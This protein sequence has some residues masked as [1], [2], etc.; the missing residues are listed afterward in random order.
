MLLV[1]DLIQS[2]NLLAEQLLLLSV[3]TC[4]STGPEDST[5]GGR[6]DGARSISYVSSFLT[7]LSEGGA[8]TQLYREE[9]EALVTSLTPSLSPD[10]GHSH[11]S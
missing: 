9:A 8:V 2:H 5:E 4:G 10:E 1:N 7:P 6:E 3:N 11:L